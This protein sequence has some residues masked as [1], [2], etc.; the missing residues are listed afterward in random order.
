[1]TRAHPW[2]LLLAALVSCQG[3]LRDFHPAERRYLA[4][5]DSYTIGV[6]VDD[7]ERWPARLLEALREDGTDLGAVEYVAGNGWASDT[8]LLF[9]PPAELRPPYELVSVLIGVNDQFRGR[10]VTVFEPTLRELLARAVALAGGR[11]ERVVVLSIPDWGFTPY[12]RNEQAQVSPQIDAYNACLERV[13]GEL[14]L[15]YVYVTDIT[16]QGLA[17]PS[18]VAWDGLHPSGRAYALFAA[19]VF[20]TVG[21]VFR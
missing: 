9:A 3:G 19:R 1:M 12:G 14:G 13:S 16:R 21:P 20:A 17:D 18:L 2:P 6:A 15:A 4:L 11:R 5:G 8:L 7:A 10:P